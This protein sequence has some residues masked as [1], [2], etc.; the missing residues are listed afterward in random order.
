MKISVN[1]TIFTLSNSVRMKYILLLLFAFTFGTSQAQLIVDSV[2]SQYLPSYDFFGSNY[3]VSNVSYVGHWRSYGQFDGT[4]SNLGLNKGFF[5]TTGDRESAIGPNL[6]SNSSFVTLI[7]G[8][9]PFL[10]SNGSESLSEGAT[11]SFDIVPHVD[12]LYFRF[13]FA[14]E[15][16]DEFVGSSF[17]DK[18][19]IFI[20]GPGFPTPTN[21][22]LLPNGEI[23]SISNV[24]DNVNNNFG[25]FAGV[26]AQYFVNNQ[27]NQNNFDSTRIAFDGF[28]QG[29]FVKLQ[30]IPIDSTYTITISVADVEDGLYDSA[31]FLESCETCNYA[32][33]VEESNLSDFTIAPNPTD[34]LLT[35]SSEGSHSFSIVQVTGKQVYSGEF[36][37]TTQLQLAHLSPGTYLIILDNGKTARFIKQ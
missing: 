6:L 30:N 3:T 11:L 23:I 22:G 13:V 31:I 17:N 14:S 15:E 10:E 4:N 36:I 25:T 8:Y 32:L 26:N 1:Q 27:A 21:I 5:I 20:E 19:G 2:E 24:H 9:S 35:L 16:Y 12:S 34:D 7:E 28:T 33:D 37:D 18:M 29:T